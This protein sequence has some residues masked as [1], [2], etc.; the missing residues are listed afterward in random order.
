MS[1]TDTQDDDGPEFEWPEPKLDRYEP[2][3]VD[4]ALETDLVASNRK[5]FDH[6]YTASGELGVLEIPVVLIGEDGFRDHF[7]YLNSEPWDVLPDE[8]GGIQ[9][10][11]DASCDYVAFSTEA[12]NNSPEWVND[13][14]TVARDPLV[15]AA[16]LRAWYDRQVG[17]KHGHM[18]RA[19]DHYDSRRRREEK[20][21]WKA[22]GVEFE[23]QESDDK[24]ECGGCSLSIP[25]GSK[26]WKIT[27]PPGRKKEDRCTVCAR[28]NANRA[29]DADYN[30]AGEDPRDHR[31]GV[32]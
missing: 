7:E 4:F 14:M 30:I 29:E 11:Q 19:N 5:H 17:R 32:S 18:V 1:Q 21:E 24:L 16:T 12:I 23:Y 6:R 20:D 2:F 22:E 13:A 3:Y 10:A 28:S 9:V 31:P 15:A 25:A 8:Y 27:I 26:V